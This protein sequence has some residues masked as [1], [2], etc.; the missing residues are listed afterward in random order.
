MGEAACKSQS[1]EFKSGATREKRE[2][3]GAGRN[4]TADKGFADL[5]LTTWRPRRM[6][7]AEA[8]HSIGCAT[9]CIEDSRSVDLVVSGRVPKGNADP[10]CKAAVAGSSETAWIVA[11]RLPLSLRRRIF[12][13]ELDGTRRRESRVKFVPD[14]AT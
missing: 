12:F 14:A 6:L 1:R 2:N 4:R 7:V 11:G 10:R 13:A 8:N 9:R 5:C 3:G